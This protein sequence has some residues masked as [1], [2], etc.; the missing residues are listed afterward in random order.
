MKKCPIKNSRGMEQYDWLR[1]GFFSSHGLQ[2]GQD[3]SGEE[4]QARRKKMTCLPMWQHFFANRVL[5]RSSILGNLKPSN[6]K[7]DLRRTPTRGILLIVFPP[8]PSYQLLPH[9]TLS[10]AENFNRPVHFFT[11]I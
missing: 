8:C 9:I 1:N 2:Y 6:K 4:L 11:V 5:Q 10:W 3:F 7:L